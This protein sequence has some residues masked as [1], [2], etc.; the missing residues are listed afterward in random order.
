MKRKT[1]LI[2]VISAVLFLALWGV[3]Y[4][5]LN[6]R[7]KNIERQGFIDDARSFLDSDEEFITTYGRISSFE[8]DT[9]YPIEYNENSDCEK[10]YMD[11]D[12]STD[13]GQ[14]Q[15]RVYHVYDQGNWRFEYEEIG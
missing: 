14:F 7:I 12:C 15:M 13:K 10:W 6:H 5:Y 11:F 8:T 3:G 1:I 4:T 2:I 9:D